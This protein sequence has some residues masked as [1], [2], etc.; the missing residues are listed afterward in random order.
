MECQITDLQKGGFGWFRSLFV[1]F[2]GDTHEDLHVGFKV[3]KSM[4]GFLTRA[5]T[6]GS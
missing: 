6:K 1:G 4:E 5:F 3:S 2:H